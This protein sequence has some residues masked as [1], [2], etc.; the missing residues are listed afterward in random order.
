MVVIS[1]IANMMG[2]NFGFGPGVA[3][4][5]QPSVL[6]NLS[7]NGQ[8]AGDEPSCGENS[9]PITSPA[10]HSQNNNSNDQLIIDTAT[11]NKQSMNNNNN[12]AG[13]PNLSNQTQ[14]HNN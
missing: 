3:N 6:N 11:A 9:N 1:F 12:S 7:N 10:A 4:G 14:Q 2:I 13:G 8:L 5:T